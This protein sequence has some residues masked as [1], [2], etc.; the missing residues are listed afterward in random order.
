M[1]DDGV[2]LRKEGP[3]A[4]VTLDRPTRR[5]AFDEKM[6]SDLE[7]VVSELRADPP[8][9]V[10]VTGA[11]DQAFCAGFDV[12]LENPQ[13]VRLSEAIHQ[14]D[15][16]S[17][18]DLIQYIRGVIDGLVNLPVPVIA[19]LNGL[20]YGGGAEL[21]CR[22]DLRVMDP[23]AVICFSEV[24]LGLMPDWGGGVGLTR[25][26]GP[27]KA[28]DLILTARPVPADEAFQIG[29]VNRISAPGRARAE[30][31][32]LA[33]T[34]ARNGPRAVR[35]ALEVIRRTPDLSCQAALSHE[36]ERA[37]ALIASGE[38][39]HGIAA[40]LAKQTPEFPEP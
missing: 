24:R 33:A 26:L 10:I 4:V 1:P 11:G 9:A 19:A 16:T 25:L 15:L 32:N 40:F 38:C 3:V 12:S 37:A 27:S 2:I 30:A 18:R 34:I 22:C 23:A 35:L 36:S 7:R 8:R 39:L 5:N 6:W 31:L 13:V 14:K 21:A 20:A 29:L 28:A 17:L